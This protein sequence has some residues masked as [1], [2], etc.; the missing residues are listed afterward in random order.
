MLA[1]LGRWS[2]GRVL[3]LALFWLLAAPILALS[4]ALAT[5]SGP[6]GAVGAVSLGLDDWRAWTVVLGP[7]TLLVAAWRR[8]R[9]QAGTGR[10][11]A[12]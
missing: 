9:K 3:A 8:A 10:R 4:L 5:R 11:D 2:A 7:P 12:V 6:P 1:L